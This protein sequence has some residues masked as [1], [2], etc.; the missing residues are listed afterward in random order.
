MLI[1][2]PKFL[3][4]GSKFSPSKILI[5]VLLVASLRVGVFLPVCCMF[6]YSILLFQVW[7]N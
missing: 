5:G 4:L 3:R 6:K 2:D 7:G 1:K